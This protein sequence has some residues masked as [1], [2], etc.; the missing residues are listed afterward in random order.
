M[1]L[2]E[3]ES[4]YHDDGQSPDSYVCPVR[5]LQPLPCTPCG[6]GLTRVNL[7]FCQAS[8]GDGDESFDRTRESKEFL[9]EFTGFSSPF[10]IIRPLGI[11]GG[12]KGLP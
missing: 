7:R 1:I 5:N 10:Q 3:L 4:C 2:I 9:R 8:S 6:A 11:V 12:L